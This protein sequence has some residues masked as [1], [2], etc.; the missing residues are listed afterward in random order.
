MAKNLRVGA[1]IPLCEEDV[2]YLPQLF[3]E[4][5]RM[6]VEVAWLLNNCS[7]ET[8]QRVR[9][10]KRTYWWRE[11]NGDFH[12]CL[13]NF[14]LEA[15]EHDFDWFIQWDADETWEPGAPE[16]LRQI[17]NTH[18]QYGLIQVRMAHAWE[19]EGEMLYTTDW[20]SERDR[21]YNMSKDFR[22]RYLSKVIAGPTNL[23]N[24]DC[25]TE[26]PVNL[27]MLHWGYS[28]NEKR[29]HHKRRW[30][31]LHGISVGRNPYGQWDTITKSGYVP[32]LITEKKLF[33]T[34]K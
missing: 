18:K 17:L 15:M 1:G 32:D 21:V 5:E 22:W 14:P 26:N 9:E 6:D 7:P 29:Q 12:N 31:R 27:W 19:H 34:I 3:A 20:A 24:G 28:T 25:R 11:F 33:E 23:F 10:F 13:R 4:I 8:I 16:K 30:D 2:E